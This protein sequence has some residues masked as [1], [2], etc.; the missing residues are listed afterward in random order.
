MKKK[1]RKRRKKIPRKKE[2]VEM[3][4]DRRQRVALQVHDREKIVP[5]KTLKRKRSQEAS[6]R[7]RKERVSCQ[8]KIKF[9]SHLMLELTSI[10]FT[11][12]A[13]LATEHFLP[14]VWPRQECHLAIPDQFILSYL[15]PCTECKGRFHFSPVATLHHQVTQLSLV[16]PYHLLAQGLIHLEHH[17]A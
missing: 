2:R 10:Q 13:H 5:K 14:T 8:S 7:S 11:I 6:N 9:P 16:P 1:K 3:E 12:L 17:P 4:T 15:K